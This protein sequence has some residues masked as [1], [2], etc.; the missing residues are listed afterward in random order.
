MVKRIDD[1]KVRITIGDDTNADEIAYTHLIDKHRYRITIHHPPTVMPHIPDLFRRAANAL[2]NPHTHTSSVQSQHGGH[3]TTNPADDAR[4]GDG[5]ADDAAGGASTA[6]EHGTDDP[7]VDADG[8]GV[9]AD[10]AGTGGDVER[11]VSEG[12]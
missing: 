5:V 1:Q 9:T 3:E 8:D 7:G 6:I 11:G 4:L 2:E 10:D 12:A